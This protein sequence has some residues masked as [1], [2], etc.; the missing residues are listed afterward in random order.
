MGTR[1]KR[2]RTSLTLDAKPDIIERLERGQT[3]ASL[4]RLYDVNESSVHTIQKSAEK[5]RSS[6]AD[7]CSPAAKKLLRVRN[8]LLE[9]M[10]MMLVTW[11]E[12][13]KGKKMTVNTT[14]ILVKALKLYK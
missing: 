5:I 10:E 8:P 12:D 14:A 6:I 7:S 4:G 3:A 13:Q 1:M 11:M 9:K 2:P